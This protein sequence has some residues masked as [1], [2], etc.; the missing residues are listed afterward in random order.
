MAVIPPSTRPQDT[1]PHCRVQR[2][3]IWGGADGRA[4]LV[5]IWTDNIWHLWV[6]L[7]QPAKARQ[8]KRSPWEAEE[9]SGLPGACCHCQFRCR[10]QAAPSSWCLPAMNS[11][12]WGPGSACR[13][14]G[15]G[16]L[17]VTGV[18]QSSP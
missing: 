10:L 8:G 12:L 2:L 17:A 14:V 7:E 6:H 15:H 16:W 5:S 18:G 13:A 1:E 11:H 3:Q 9:R 4:R